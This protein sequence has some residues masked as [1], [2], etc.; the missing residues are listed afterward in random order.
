MGRPVSFCA[1][2]AGWVRERGTSAGPHG[3]CIRNGWGVPCRVCSCLYPPSTSLPL[4]P[5]IPPPRPDLPIAGRTH[6]SAGRS[7]HPNLFPAGARTPETP[8]PARSSDPIA[9]DARDI[10]ACLPSPLYRLPNWAGPSRPKLALGGARS[11]IYRVGGVGRGSEQALN[12]HKPFHSS[13]GWRRR[14][15]PATAAARS[16]ALRV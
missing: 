3:S 15:A 8:P 10:D 11:R 4:E 6:S 7:V 13:N 5:L 12:S 9:I 14:G 16:S 1:V 2:S